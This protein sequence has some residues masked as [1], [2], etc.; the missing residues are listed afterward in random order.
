MVGVRQ[1]KDKGKTVQ[2]RRW[3]AGQGRAGS[4]SNTG[5]AQRYAMSVRMGF[6]TR[7]MA[8]LRAWRPV[9]VTEH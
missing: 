6:K 9:P 2:G 7:F 5:A 3:G 1:G 4:K 8:E